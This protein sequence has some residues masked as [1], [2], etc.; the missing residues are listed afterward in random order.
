MMVNISGNKVVQ[1][2]VGKFFLAKGIFVNMDVYIL[3]EYG[4]LEAVILQAKP[5]RCD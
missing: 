4:H 1:K 5:R 2:I 3:S